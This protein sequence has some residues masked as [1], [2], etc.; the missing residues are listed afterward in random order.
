MSLIRSLEHQIN[1]LEKKIEKE[2]D[3]MNNLEL[4]YEHDELSKIKFQSKKKHNE[5]MIKLMELRIRILK[6][7]LVKR[8]HI[9][10]AG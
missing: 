4:K 7:E 3:K 2:K 8:R 6:G 10:H 5:E 1:R 9:E